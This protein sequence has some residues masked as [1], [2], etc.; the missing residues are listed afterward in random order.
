[1]YDKS[2][3]IFR[4]D[5]RLFD[6]TALNYAL[7]N[8]NKVILCF[9][10]DEQQIKNN[11]YLSKFSLSFLIESLIEMNENLKKF[12]SKIYFCYG[13]PDKI[14]SKII[15]E[16][17]IDA[18][19]LNKDYTPFSINRDEI[20]KNLCD[21]KKVSFNSYF[22]ICLNEIEF[23]K[24]N[25]NDN[26]K[27]FTHFYNKAKTFIV[28]KPNYDIFLNFKFEDIFN[29]EKSNK[30][31]KNIS[32]K[33]YSNKL[34]IEDEKI[35]EKLKE[36]FNLDNKL[37]SNSKIFSGRK[38]AISLLN[39]L[40]NLI[41]YEKTRNFPILEKT[42]HLSAHLKYGTV[43]IR[44]VYHT[45]AKFLNLNHPLIRQLYFRDFFISIAY[46]YPHIFGNSFY[47]KYDKI[48]WENNINKFNAWKNAKTGFPIVDAGMNELNKTGF[49]HNRLRMITASFLVKDL[50]VDWRY[51]EKYFAQKLI[52]Y[53]PCVNN[54][55]WQWASSTGCDAAPYFRI[56]NPWLQ[57][58]KFDKDCLYI[59]KWIPQLKDISS[60]QIHDLFKTKE[61]I[62]N[63]PLPLVDHKIESDKAKSY[64]KIVN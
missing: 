62:K 35:L 37:H 9:I 34:S 31:I 6:N 60:K 54:G 44:E 18:V 53:D 3:F 16:L 19:F 10:F 28:K 22:D 33:F 50:H 32:N 46:N 25:N 5:L 55:N 14:I 7:K 23:I 21:K 45:I 26:Y 24:T 57:Q 2:L 39:N 4:R 48:K 49:M 64:F 1:M 41:D 56:F 38:K 8:S 12:N 61:K 30:F 36:K 59:K 52:D 63:Y 15:D 42:S 29:Y 51:G 17:L 40:E 47:Q 11:E 13:K 27:V 58:K 43:S 20:I